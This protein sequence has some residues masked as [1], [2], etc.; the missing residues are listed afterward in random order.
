MQK[1][2]RRGDRSSQ[3][4]YNLTEDNLT[5][6][7]N[8]LVC[9]PFKNYGYLSNQ[10]PLLQ[11]MYSFFIASRFINQLQFE[12]FLLSMNS[13]FIPGLVMLCAGILLLSGLLYHKCKVT[14]CIHNHKKV[15]SRKGE[16]PLD[17]VMAMFVYVCVAILYSSFHYIYS[18]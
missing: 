13:Y 9:S 3:S 10:R 12:F 2:I 15:D 5:E 1:C 17:D 18:L 11:L 6:D 16:V 14:Y 8:H 7:N 4:V